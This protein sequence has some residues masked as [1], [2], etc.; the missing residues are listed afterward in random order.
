MDVER[1]ARRAVSARRVL[2]MAVRGVIAEDTESRVHW[3][4]PARKALTE[5]DSIL[6]FQGCFGVCCVVVVYQGV[7]LR[8][9]E[10]WLACEGWRGRTRQSLLADQEGGQLKGAA[11]SSLASPSIGKYCIVRLELGQV[12]EVDLSVDSQYAELSI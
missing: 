2:A 3:R 11:C 8:W 4:L 12:E 6:S 5:L 9:R 1:H 7:A 10:V